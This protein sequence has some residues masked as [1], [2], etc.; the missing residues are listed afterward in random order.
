MQESL[1]Q[2][3]KPS[4]WLG[5]ISPGCGN[6]AEIIN[7]LSI[8]LIENSYGK[9]HLAL[10][11]KAFAFLRG[12]KRENYEL[13]YENDTVNDLAADRIGRCSL[14]SMTLARSAFERAA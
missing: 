7:N 5:L 13:I 12:V 11:D 1:R 3:A 10:S 8:D 14:F 6:N 4:C 9:D 2:L